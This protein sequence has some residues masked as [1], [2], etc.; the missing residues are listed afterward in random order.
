MAQAKCS[1]R[2]GEGVEADYVGLEMKP[3]GVNC[4]SCNGTGK[5][6][7]GVFNPICAHHCTVCEG[8]DHHWMYSG[9][10]DENGDPLM[11]CKHCPALRP[12][13]DEDDG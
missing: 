12:V 1:A 10:E 5:V 9:E 8:G 11:S 3:A 2:D 6:P 7:V 13:T 4:S